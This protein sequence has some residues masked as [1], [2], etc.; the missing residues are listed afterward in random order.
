MPK[1]LNFG[2]YLPYKP[3]EREFGCWKAHYVESVRKIKGFP[4]SK[5]K[6]PFRPN[7]PLDL[8]SFHSKE[9]AFEYRQSLYHRELTDEEK[10]KYL[11][12]SVKRVLNKSEY[13]N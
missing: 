9:K 4:L 2:W 11:Y 3:T 7:L 6:S 12:H 13:R 5:V 10:N 1:C 8:N